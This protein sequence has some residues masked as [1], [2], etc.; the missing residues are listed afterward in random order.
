MTIARLQVTPKIESR[1]SSFAADSYS[2][3]GIHETL[4]GKKYF[5]KRPGY[6]LFSNQL[7]ASK[8]Q[9]I[10]QALSGLYAVSNNTLYTVAASGST[11][12]L[13][14]IST[15]NTFP[16]ISIN[17]TA[18][19][20]ATSSA[21]TQDFSTAG[22]F[23]FVVP[24]SVTKVTATII[25]GGGAG[26]NGHASGYSA[27]GGGGSGGYVVQ[28]IT[29]TPGQTV[30]IVVGTGGTV[31]GA[32]GGAGGNGTSSI[33]TYAATPYTAGGG[34]G[35]GANTGS[36]GT[37]GAGGTPS[38]TAGTAV[39]S[40]N[41][42]GTRGGNSY[43]SV[44]TGTTT[45]GAGGPWNGGYGAEVAG[46][47]GI[48]GG[49]GGGGTGSNNSGT[50]KAGGAGAAGFVRITYTPVLTP[51]TIPGAGSTL[52]M[53]DGA[54]AY[55]YTP[56]GV[57][58]T[59]VTSAGFPTDPLCHGAVYIDGYMLVFTTTGRL[60]NSA[61]EDP[62]TWDALNFV[63]A[64]VEPDQGVAL[65]K[66]LNYA[67]AFGQWS[68]EFFFDAAYA[69]GSPF[70]VSTSSRLGIGC[71]SGNT[72][73]NSDQT[74]VFVGQ[75]QTNGKA[76]YILDGLNPIKISTRYIERYL[77][78]DTLS[79]ARSYCTK[80]RGHTLYI[81]TMPDSNITLVYD[82]EEQSWYRWT[83]GAAETYFLPTFY[84]TDETSYYV[85]DNLNSQIY[86][87]SS[88]TYQD[89]GNPI[90]C[91]IVLPLEDSGTNKPKFYRRVEVVGDK[92][93]G[94]A[95]ISRS[96]ND[97]GG[98]SIARGVSLSANRSWLNQWGKSNRRAWQIL[99]YD[100][101][102]LRLEALEVTFDVG[103]MDNAQ[104]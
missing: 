99:V 96:D 10:F 19:K 89:N 59:K 58:A 74:L 4:D 39:V 3:N 45:G 11:I 36:G 8:A 18:N 51:G 81:L 34:S 57:T 62:S 35:G 68:T 66:H 80:V 55:T 20:T 91:R 76:V 61:I 69:T 6:T 75:S 37:A 50:W 103:G 53:H 14:A 48:Y 21:I 13:G 86:R 30:S 82:F 43:Y 70:Q 17:Q 22:S 84:T 2:T 31:S 65:A 85:V 47:P 67:V 16:S 101:I 87:L 88:I 92:V 77:D 102:P 71:A 33:V 46:S 64:E 7:P 56:G 41:P 28:N 27:S 73:A 93:T 24:S 32:Q 40:P 83:S 95:Y 1:T 90:Y 9:G 42:D 94:T 60:Y 25:G 26:G 29:V 79:N 52:F 104:G 98:Y 72:V 100:N 23:S 54:V 63:S 5:V 12:S 38:G 97:Y 15:N 44:L 78:S 49:G